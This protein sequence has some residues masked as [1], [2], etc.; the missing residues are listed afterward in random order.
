MSKLTAAPWWAKVAIKIALGVVPIPYEKIRSALTGNRGGMEIPEYAQQIFERVKEQFMATSGSPEGCTIMEIGPGGSLLTG[1]FAKAMGFER[2]ILI[3]VGDFA[4]RDPDMYKECIG[5]LSGPDQE[6][7]EHE[8]NAQGDVLSALDSIG[9]HY[10][11]DGILSLA[12]LGNSSV[13]FSFSNAV[14]E[15]IK[16]KDFKDFS[17]EL[18]RVHKD[19]SMSV[20]QIDYKDHL[21][22][23]LDNLRFSGNVWESP[24]FTND[25]FYTNRYRHYEI[26]HY[27][28][29]A[30][31]SL[32]KEELSRWE[33]LPI[34]RKQ[35]ALEFQEID[36]DELL[37][38]GA[39]LVTR[40][41]SRLVLEK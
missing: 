23:G 41:E 33:K 5:I 26:R 1:V 35:M 25:G 4:S 12:S 18:S 14:L 6:I 20:H 37:V 13:D 24:L 2:C 28:E 15:H 40:K 36:D 19:N 11:T 30:G 7:F 10:Y 32:I 8:L 16:R 29:N 3:D 9:I 27:L 17:K 39:F 21:G 22:G 38:S 34:S 31:F